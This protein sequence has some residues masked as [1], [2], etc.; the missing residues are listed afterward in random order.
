[1]N[2]KSHIAKEFGVHRNTI[3]NRLGNVSF[4]AKPAP[5]K[6]LPNELVLV[7]DGTGI[8]PDEMLILSYE[9][10]S[11]QPLAWLFDT[12]ETFN[13]WFTLLKEIKKRYSVHAIVSDGQKGLIKASKLSFPNAIHQRC[14]AHIIRLSFALLTRNPKTEAGVELRLMIRMLGKV[15]NDF[16]AKV[17]KDGFENWNKQYEQFLKEKSFNPENGRKWYTHK[18]LRAVRSLVKNAIG[19]MFWYVNDSKIPNTTNVVEGGINSPLA[20]LLHR[21]R[22]IGKQLKE[23]LVLYYLYARRKTKK[24][25]RSCA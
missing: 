24:T 11:D 9:Y 5:L 22:G 3:S 23:Q 25:T 17:W 12:H 15:R 16:E 1:M 19:D 8:S 7:L 10:L 2:S 4:M 21:H 14:L 13:S 6:K 20:E 18:K